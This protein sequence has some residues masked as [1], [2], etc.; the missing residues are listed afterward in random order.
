MRLPNYEIPEGFSNPYDYLV[1]LSKEGLKRLGWNTS[2][3]HIDRL[4]MELGDV[5]VAWENNNYDFATYFLIVRD[6][7]EEAKRRG[8]MTGS[9]RGSGYGSVLLRCLGISYGPDPLEYG[10]LW[11]RFLGFDWKKFII[12]SDFGL[13]KERETENK[14]SEASNDYLDKARET[15]NDQGGID[16]Y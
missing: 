2:Q 4:K 13:S 16:R 6:Y 5:K 10:L 8:I 12:E 1:H 11:E 14:P 7:M 15:E 9:G 3:K